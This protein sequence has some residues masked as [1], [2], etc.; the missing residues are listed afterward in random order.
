MDQK[1]RKW[2]HHQQ[3]AVAPVTPS[4]PVEADRASKSRKK[5]RKRKHLPSDEGPPAQQRI[6]HVGI[7][8]TNSN[9]L[10]L[11]AVLKKGRPSGKPRNVADKN[12]DEA[13]SGGKTGIES[14]L[15]TLSPRNDDCSITKVLAMDCEMVGAGLDGKRSILARVSLVNIWGNVVYDKHVKPL[16]KVTDYRTKVSGIRASNLKKGESFSVVQKEVAEL[17]LGR[18]LVGHSLRNDLKILYLSHPKKDMRDTAAYPP[19]RSLN[20]R[21]QALRHIASDLLGVQIQ[22]G[23]HCSVED[24]RAVMYIYQKIKRDWE[25]L[26]TRRR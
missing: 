14:L 18:V 8:R 15:K 23:E 4:L 21:P 17:I 19:L 13:K 11:Q 16:E 6:P 24:A 9:W 2:Q 20:G 25:A 26:L 7:D 5:R 10:Q 1:K 22:T 12:L 3:Q